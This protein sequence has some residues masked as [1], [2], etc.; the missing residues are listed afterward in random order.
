[1]KKKEFA[2]ELKHVRDIVGYAHSRLEPI[3]RGANLDPNDVW[4]ALDYLE[5]VLTRLQ[6]LQ[7]E[8]KHK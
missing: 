2:D 7:N 1:M 4:V 6:T 8:L 5:S 3:R